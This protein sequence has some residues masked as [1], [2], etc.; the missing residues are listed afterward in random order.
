MKAI[1]IK[2][3]PV[4]K[5]EWIFIAGEGRNQAMDGAP[6]K[7][8]KTASM[9]L[10]KDSKEAKGLIA[11]IDATWE[12]YKTE[13]HKIKAATQPKSLG[14]KI[15]KDKDTDEETN[16]LIF[17]YKTN[18][19][20]PDGKP[21]NIKTYNAK[22]AEVDMGETIIGNGSLGVIHGSMGGYEY[23]GSFG[24]SLYLSAVQIAKLVEGSSEAV[25][26]T[27]LSAVAGDDG[28]EST[29]DSMP[30]VGTQPD[31]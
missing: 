15:V 20:W 25:E 16:D 11:Q 14:Y 21:N 10:N 8:Q 6:E 12:Q 9:I 3:P 22:G 18:S 5:L 27:D 28:F 4:G 2:Q 30:A 19:R 23:A 24:I 31:L 26:T 7:M 17:S 29:G 13:N 1:K